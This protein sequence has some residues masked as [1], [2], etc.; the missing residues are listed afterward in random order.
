[1]HKSEFDLK[2]LLDEISLGFGHALAEKKQTL[3]VSPQGGDFRLKADRDKI[4][5]VFVN[6]IDNA[7]KYTKPSGRIELSLLEQ[8][9][10]VCVAVR[11]NGIGIP[12]EHLGRVFERFYRVDKARSRELGGTG[13]GLSIAKHIVHIH[14]GKIT[15]ESEPG[16]G[17][18]VSVTLPKQ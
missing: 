2:E 3:T 17:T 12:K 8:D 13:L 11:D 18:T 6:L 1:V 5:Q 4:E 16:Q 7:I 9:Q 10:A 14:N 15:I